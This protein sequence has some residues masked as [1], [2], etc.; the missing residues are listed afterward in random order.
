MEL[1]RREGK[2]RDLK[3]ELETTRENEAKQSALVG[4]FRQRLSE[5][6]ATAG[7]LE[8]A[9]SRSELA[10]QALNKQNADLQDRIIDLEARIRFRTFSFSCDF[11][12]TKTE[13]EE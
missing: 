9:A 1:D 12:E 6:E 4:T 2:I 8:G 7:T 10:V 5:Y 11:D 13:A 3:V